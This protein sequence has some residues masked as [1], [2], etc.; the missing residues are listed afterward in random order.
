MTI[1]ERTYTPPVFHITNASDEQT[2][3]M[4]TVFTTLVNSGIEFVEVRR[5]EKKDNAIIA[6]AHGSF[7]EDELTEI[8]EEIQEVYDMG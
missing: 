8:M 5:S 6:V 2:I 1:Y 4:E 7:S 3:M